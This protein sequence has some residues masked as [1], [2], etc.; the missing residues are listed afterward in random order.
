MLVKLSVKVFSLKAKTGHPSDANKMV[1]FII[2]TYT[3]TRMFLL[4]RIA[5][6]FKCINCTAYSCRLVTQFIIILKNT[7]QHIGLNRYTTS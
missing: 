4:V 3:T 5:D 7:Y 6:E 2:D 1:S